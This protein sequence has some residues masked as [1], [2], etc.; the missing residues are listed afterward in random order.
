MKG[1]VT[2][3]IILGVL[4]VAS[5]ISLILLR[6]NEDSWIKSESGVWIKHGAPSS[7]PSEVLEQQDA[8]NC[9]LQLY[10]QEKTKRVEFNSQCLGTCGDYAVDI[11]HVPRT[12]YDNL[13][14]NQCENYRNGNVKH[15]VELDKDGNVVK[16]V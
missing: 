11:V 8:I 9:A 16:G 6:G 4:I 2:I 10:E 14:E 5:V 1:Q 15:F 7:T 3:F 13:V 12:S